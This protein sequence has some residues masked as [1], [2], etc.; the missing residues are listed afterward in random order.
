L[1]IDPDFELF[2]YLFKAAISFG[3]S[4]RVAPYGF[5]SLQL[6][7]SRSSEYPHITLRDSNKEWHRGWFYLKNQDGP[8]S[9][10]KYIV[11]R[12]VPLKDPDSWSWGLPAS[13]QRRLGDHLQ[14]LSRLKEVYGLTGVGV[15]HAYF[16][17]GIAPLMERCLR[18]F[19]MTAD[20]SAEELQAVLAAPGMP[21]P[22]DEEV[23][24]RFISSCTGSSALLSLCS[25]RSCA[26]PGCA[27][28]GE[29]V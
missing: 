3:E 24:A 11:D 18:I 15:M 26:P 22:S 29:F 10:P 17:L 20:H 14:C 1:G 13:N 6:R 9:L 16:R 23:A 7:R 27:I 4:R 5:C 28:T 8:G 12:Q 19:E 2:K 25:A 21:Y